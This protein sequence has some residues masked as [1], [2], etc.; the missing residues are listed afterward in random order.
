MRHVLKNQENIDLEI[1]IGKILDEII[2]MQD[3]VSIIVPTLNGLKYLE[4]VMD[5]VQKHTKWPFE[6]IVVDNC[7]VDNTGD[8]IVKYQKNMDIKRIYLPKNETRSHARNAGI[9]SARGDIIIFSDSD[10]ISERDYVTKHME[11]NV[12]NNDVICGENWVKIYTFYYKDFLG[13]L[14]RNLLI[15]KH[16]YNLSTPMN[17][18]EDKSC[19]I[20]EEKIIS[21]EYKKFSFTYAVNDHGYQIILDRYGRNLEGYKFPWSFFVTNNCSARREKILEAGMFDEDY[22][23][24]GCE[25]LDLGYRLYKKGCNFKK[26]DIESI[27]Q[28]HAIN[29]M[30]DGL[31]NIYYFSEKYNSVDVLLYYFHNLI[32]LDINSANEIV[33]EIESIEHIE[34]YKIILYLFKDLLRAARN[35]KYSDLIDK[36]SLIQELKSLKENVGYN[37]E[38]LRRLCTEIL[39]Q[40]KCVKLISALKNLIK[41][42]LRIN[43]DDLSF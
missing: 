37:R 32:T 19:L 33:K 12:G 13:Y 15:N 10:M 11:A 27:H 20:N 31:K 38:L 3:M 41:Y 21:G 28:E 9:A 26:L 16:L 25:D 29:Y 6:V 8:L 40:Y 7:S 35:N 14:K 1:I 39:E 24:W 17:K 18:I 5:S 43:F 30:E 23:G 34:D 36:T 4:Q 2:N 22:K 42:M